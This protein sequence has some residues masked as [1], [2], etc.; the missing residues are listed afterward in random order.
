MFFRV[1]IFGELHC[2]Y[3]KSLVLQVPQDGME[4]MMRIRVIQYH[5]KLGCKKRNQCNNNDHLKACP[6]AHQT[7]WALDQSPSRLPF[8]GLQLQMEILC[9]CLCSPLPRSTSLFPKIELAELSLVRFWP[10][11]PILNNIC[12]HKEF[13]N[14]TSSHKKCFPDSFSP[15]FVCTAHQGLHP[16]WAPGNTD[17]GMNRAQTRIR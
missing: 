17:A 9:K 12:L 8:S 10:L 1:E 3:L 14:T 2:L 11:W 15:G 6:T 5:N 7:Q 4:D 13:S 16:E